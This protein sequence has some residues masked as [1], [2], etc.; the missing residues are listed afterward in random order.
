LRKTCSN[1]R[2]SWRAENR[3]SPNKQAC[4]GRFSTAYYALFHLLIAEAV[5]NWRRTDQR[6]KLARAFDHGRMKQASI[7]TFNKE[8]SGQNPRTVADL[9]KVAN[10]FIHL[11]QFRNKPDY[12]N[13]FVL[14]PT[15]ARGQVALA[16][17]A[18]ASWA[19][20]RKE[21]IAQDYLLALMIHR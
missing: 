15:E 11:Q 21:T 5:G 3:E 8:F 1:R 17:D 10:A 13:S 2:T 20:V 6:A 9:K 14:T 18:F 12:D 16:S 4:G 7:K 19:A